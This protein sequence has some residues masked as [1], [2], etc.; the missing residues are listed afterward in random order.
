MENRLGKWI[1]LVL[2]I[3]ISIGMEDVKRMFYT[4]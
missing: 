2:G 3:K 1:I 4:E